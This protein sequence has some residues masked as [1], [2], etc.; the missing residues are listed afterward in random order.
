MAKDGHNMEAS[1]K[2]KIETD[3]ISNAGR[4]FEEASKNAKEFARKIAGR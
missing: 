4:G 2:F 1:V 3:E